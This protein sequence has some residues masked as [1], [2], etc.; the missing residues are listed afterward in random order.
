[1]ERPRQILQKLK[2]N[3]IYYF[4]NV[5]D[6][7]KRVFIE[8]YWQFNSDQS[9]LMKQEEFNDLIQYVYK[10][11]GDQQPVFAIVKELFDFIDYRSDGV[12]DINEWMQCFKK[13]EVLLLLYHIV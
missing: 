7:F 5:K 11:N 9:G 4:I 8:Y 12:I 10:K 3:I 13:I 1:M 2:T 6:A